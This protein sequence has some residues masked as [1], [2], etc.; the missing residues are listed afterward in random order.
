[1]L[2]L[3]LLDLVH[4][5]VPSLVSLSRKSIECQIPLRVS[6]LAT[7]PLLQISILRVLLELLFVLLLFL[8]SVFGFIGFLLDEEKVGMGDL[9]VVGNIELDLPV[10]NKLRSLLKDF[11]T[12]SLS[13]LPRDLRDLGCK[14][15]LLDMQLLFGVVVQSGNVHILKHT[16]EVTGFPVINGQ[17]VEDPISAVSLLIKLEIVLATTK[18]LVLRLFYLSLEEWHIVEAHD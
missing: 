13:Q 3:F 6:S 10:F 17:L 11:Y 2:V 16:L 8:L 15:V 7:L 1:M 12:M 9:S 18:Y 5:T 4:C 14:C